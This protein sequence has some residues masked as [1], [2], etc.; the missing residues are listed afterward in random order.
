MKTRFLAI[1]LTLLLLSACHVAA[2]SA[3][4]TVPTLQTTD[5]HRP[6]TQT[7]L[8]PAITPTR[9]PTV[10]I[11][12]TQTPIASRTP[13][14][15]FTYVFPLQP[16]DVAAYSEGVKAHGYPAT[17]IFAPVGTKFVAVTN[18]VV[19]F[20]SFTDKWNPKTDDPALRG[21]LAVAIIGN[22]GMRYYG[23]HLSGIALGIHIGM[24]VLAGQL[25]GYVGE[26]GNAEGKESHLHFGISHPTSPDDW[27]TRRGEVDPFP[28]LK[29]WERGISLI[30]KLP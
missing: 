21:G 2:K 17:D 11:A 13:G 3:P 15:L 19:E 5:T 26:S 1:L 12:D 4:A 22:D 6:Q 28:Y 14:P 8:P 9:R 24:S 27:L 10:T 25:L 30:P 23:S 7:A 18:G 20:V 16:Q 29:A